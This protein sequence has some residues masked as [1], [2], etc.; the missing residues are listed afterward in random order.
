MQDPD[1]PVAWRWDQV[2]NEGDWQTGFTEH[3][4]PQPSPTVRNVTPLYSRPQPAKIEKALSRAL[5]FIESLTADPLLIGVDDVEMT[6]EDVQEHAHIELA[7]IRAA[8]TAAPASA[9]E[10]VPLNAFKAIEAESN[11]LRELCTKHRNESERLRKL[12]IS[13]REAMLVSQDGLSGTDWRHMIAFID[14][15][16]KQP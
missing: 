14:A 1:K 4:E 5:E 9:A 3:G 13:C 7:S 12:L 8:L 11:Q 10:P 6:L 2:M 16:L 15:A